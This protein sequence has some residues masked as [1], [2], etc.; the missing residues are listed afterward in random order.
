[1]D[2]P[3]GPRTPDV[4]SA[5]DAGGAARAAERAGAG[6]VRVDPEQVAAEFR[7]A[8]RELR[9]VRAD[10]AEADGDLE[11][12]TMDWLRERQDAETTLQAYR[13]RALEVRAR[14]RRLRSAGPEAPCPT[15]GRV[16]EAHYDEVLAELGEQWEALVQDGSWWRSRWEQLEPKPASLV[17]LEARCL[18][19]HAALEAGSERVE[20]LRARL[21]ELEEEQAPAAARDLSGPEGAVAAALRRIHDARLARAADLL[22][23]RA[24][25]FV[26]RMSGGR[27]LAVSRD[28]SSVRLEGSEGPLS[29]MSEEDVAT[30]KLAIRLAAASLVAASGRV[31]AS[32]PI[33]E[34]FDR[35]DEETRIR[36]LVLVRDLLPELPRVILFSRGDVVDARPELFDYVLEIREEGAAAVPPL[37][38]ALAG[39][40]RVTFG[41]PAR[42]APMRV[43]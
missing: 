21:R 31:L 36:T 41:V 32:L 27:V 39:P 24:S 37:R 5:A 29:P 3:E 30:G 25:R 6:A 38:S 4:T 2:A 40:G 43:G 42:R 18:R 14:I 34:P 35:M 22:G 9:A 12:A 16:L 1:P 13:E 7:A 19:L 10:L 11:A 20:L 33:E 8:E 26:C 23:R 28:G 17:E 15:C